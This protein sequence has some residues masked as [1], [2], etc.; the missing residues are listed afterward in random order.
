MSD[1]PSIRDHRITKSYFRICSTDKSRS[2]APFYL[3]ARRPIANRAEGAFELLR[4]N[5]GGDRPSQTAQ[6]EMSSARIHG[7]ELE[8][9]Y[10]QGGISRLA[11]PMLAHRLQ[12]LPP[13]LHKTGHSPISACSEGSRGLSVSLRERGIFTTAT[14]SP[15][16]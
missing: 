11:P 15:G 6:L 5:F 4:Y 2:Q 9:K 8:L 13:I 14:I 1:D 10:A 3:C 7:S 12:R 16:H